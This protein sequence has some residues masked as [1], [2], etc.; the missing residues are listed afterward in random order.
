MPKAIPPKDVDYASILT[1]R[2]YAF[3]KSNHADVLDTT[4]KYTLITIRRTNY[5][6]FEVRERRGQY[7]QF[8][9]TFTVEP[10]ARNFYESLCSK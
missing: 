3:V 8:V 10:E 1:A 2:E 6:I 5:Q 7:L 9:K 4:D